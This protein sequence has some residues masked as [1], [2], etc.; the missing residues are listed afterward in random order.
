MVGDNFGRNMKQLHLVFLAILFFSASIFQSQTLTKLDKLFWSK[1]YKAS[2]NER[3]ELCG[4]NVSLRNDT[5]RLN[6]QLDSLAMEI[7]ELE[8][9]YA[10]LS[11]TS[12]TKLSELSANLDAKSKELSKKETSLAEKDKK[13]R[14]LQSL[15]A[16]Q[17]SILNTLNSTIKSALLGFASDEFTVEMKNGK[18]YVSLSNKLLFKSGSAEVEDKGK[19]AIKKLSDVLNKNPTIDI[20]IEGHTDSIPIKTATY[21]DNWDLSVARSTN[22]VRMLCNDFEVNPKR[23]TA[24]GRGEFFPAASNATP[25]GRA[26]NRRTDII[27]SPKLEELFRLFNSPKK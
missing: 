23:V 7:K 16:K 12:G 5:T 14:E 18:V 11:K 10:S 24:A 21:R 3:D 15:L 6:F 8:G 1:R 2:L 19:E 20:S 4:K 26:R 13:L 9:R 22:I 17:D 27:L 25:E